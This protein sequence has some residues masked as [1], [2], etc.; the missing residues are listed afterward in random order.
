MLHLTKSARQGTRQETIVVTER[1]P[2]FLQS[3]CEFT[4]SVQVEAQKDYWLLTLHTT[5]RLNILCQRCMEEFQY[6]YDN[7]TVIALCHSDEVASRL[8]DD[9]ESI[10]ISD[11]RVDLKELVTDE[12]HLY[13]PEFHPNVDECNW[14]I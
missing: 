10:V 2:H 3:P 7:V 12:L 11:D 14:F 13:A 9:Y 1:L 4:A 8:Q 6:P 5:A